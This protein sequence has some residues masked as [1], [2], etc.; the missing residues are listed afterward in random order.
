[1]TNETMINGNVNLNDILYIESGIMHREQLFVDIYGKRIYVPQSSDMYLYRI[2]NHSTFFINVVGYGLFYYDP[3]A[4]YVRQLLPITLSR[5]QH[6]YIIAV[7]CLKDES[8]ESE[9][10]YIHT[11]SKATDAGGKSQ[12]MCMVIDIHGVILAQS[13]LGVS[14]TDLALIEN[15]NANIRT[16]AIELH[17]YPKGSNN[18][19]SYNHCIIDPSNGNLLM[20]WVKYDPLT[21]SITTGFDDPDG[22]MYFIHKN[23]ND[24]PLSLEFYQNQNNLYMKDETESSDWYTYDR[25][26]DPSRTVRYLKHV[27]KSNDNKYQSLP[28]ELHFIGQISRNLWWRHSLYNGS[29]IEMFGKGPTDADKSASRGAIWSIPGLDTEEGPHSYGSANDLSDVYVLHIESDDTNKPILILAY[30]GKIRIIQADLSGDTGSSTVIIE[31]DAPDMTPIIIK[32]YTE[33]VDIIYTDSLYRWNRTTKR[34]TNIVQFKNPINANELRRVD[35]INVTETGI[36]EIFY[37]RSV[38]SVADVNIIPD[39]IDLQIIESRLARLE[40]IINSDLQK[41]IA[42]LEYYINNGD[43]R[44][45]SVNR[46]LIEKDTTKLFSDPRFTSMNMGILPTLTYQAVDNNDGTTRPEIGLEIGSYIDFHN[47]YHKDGICHDGD[48]CSRIWVPSTKVPELGGNMIIF[49]NRI[50]RA[51]LEYMNP[52]NIPADNFLHN[53]VNVISSG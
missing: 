38:K 1:M 18:S 40:A 6:E 32:E 46:C 52:N 34:F 16:T 44:A 4:S 15:I 53:L 29:I 5:Y 3:T 10:L 21:N 19:S 8:L 7:P 9:I 49:N 22:P 41:R 39:I 17:C 37:G 35:R 24:P 12:F 28:S 51:N 48:A 36:V 45:N 50:S 25:I 42:S 30:P 47:V 20:Y 26:K 27:Y 14:D 33:Y 31:T 11:F 23:T 2:R 13:G 43:F